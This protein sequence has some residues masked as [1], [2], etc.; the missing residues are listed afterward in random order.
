MKEA[1]SAD[2]DSEIRQDGLKLPD[3]NDWHRA[4]NQASL[5]MIGPL[6]LGIQS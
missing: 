1:I 2:H 6:H 4:K 5:L 3:L